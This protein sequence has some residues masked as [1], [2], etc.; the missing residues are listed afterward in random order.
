MKE[1]DL[2]IKNIKNKELLPI[3]FF[4]GEEPYFIDLAVSVL[5]NEVLQEDEKAFGQTV[6][7]GK[8]TNLAQ[9]ISYAQQFPMMGDY[10]LIIV[11]EAQDLRFDEKAGE[12][13]SSYV[14]NPIPTTILVL[15][16][17]HKKMDERKKFMKK[18][19]SKSMAFLSEPVKDYQLGA[20]ITNECKKLGI[21]V[22]PSIPAL[23][24]DH[25]GNDLSR[26]RSELDKLKLILKENQVLD[27]KVVETHI[28]I[29]KEFNSFELQKAIG[30]KDKEKAMRIAYF[31][32]KSSKSSGGTSTL[33]YRYFCNIIFFHTMKGLPQQDVLKTMGLGHAF[34]L[35][36]VRDAASRYNLKQATRV[37]SIIRD[38]HMRER[39]VGSAAVDSGELLCELVYKILNVDKVKVDL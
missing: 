20:W 25:L 31:M 32:S 26:I 19:K 34:F 7:Y 5:E 33:F 9:I 18:L 4:H 29:S 10:N 8:E 3:Y 12:I 16:Y 2:L 1:L 23:L 27:G 22:E 6:L 24:A 28:G 30:Q 37:I 21:P 13:F 35:N 15:A 14:E 17:K 36:E 38:Y 39:G 11:K